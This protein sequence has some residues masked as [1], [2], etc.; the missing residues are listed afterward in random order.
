MIT[1]H[2]EMFAMLRG[3]EDHLDRIEEK[4][5]KRG[6]QVG[7]IYL[8]VCIVT[9]IAVFNFFFSIYQTVTFIW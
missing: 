6:K 8:F 1:V 3:L 5:E 7:S 4:V 2:E 9:L